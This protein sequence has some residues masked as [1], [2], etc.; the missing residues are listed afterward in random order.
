MGLSGAEKALVK[1]T[2]DAYVA[3]TPGN[4]SDFFVRLFSENPSFLALFKSFPPSDELPGHKEVVK[5]AVIDFQFISKLLD[6][7]DENPGAFE[8]ALQKLAVTHKKRNI[9][10][11]MFERFRVTLFGALT[12]KLGAGVMTGEVVQAWT[13]F[14]AAIVAVVTPGLL[15]ENPTYIPYFKVFKIQNGD[16]QAL[17]GTP[18]MLKQTELNFNFFGKLVNGIGNDEPFKGDLVKL[19]V[20]HKAY[21]ITLDMFNTLGG[22]ILAELA[23]KLGSDL[24][25]SEANA[26]WLKFYTNIV[27][28]VEP[29]L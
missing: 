12:D 16:L 14:Y 25:T 3:D 20:R 17:R 18:E 9:T 5:Q 22:V 8:E 1:S 2:W 10:A 4:G 29:G 7:V 19:S 6:N 24:Y 13:K 27:K 28:I 26:A 23:D 11:D 15:T 21:R